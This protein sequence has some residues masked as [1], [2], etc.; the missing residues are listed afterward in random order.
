MKSK[1]EERE[2]TRAVKS[3][4]K[5]VKSKVENREEKRVKRKEE[6]NR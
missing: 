4:D 5:H 2:K 6:G 1:A 3:K